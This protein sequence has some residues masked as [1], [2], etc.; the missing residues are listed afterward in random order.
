METILVQANV[1]I[2]A[3]GDIKLHLAM[4]RVRIAKLGST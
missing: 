4:T 1:K 2:A 3:L